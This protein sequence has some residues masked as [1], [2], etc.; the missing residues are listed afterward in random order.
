MR[1]AMLLAG[2]LATL[3]PGPPPAQADTDV[4]YQGLRIPAPAGWEVHHLGPRSTECLRFDRH[5]VY[6][7]SAGE[8]QDCPAHAVGRTTAIHVEPLAAQTN[9]LVTG[10]LARDGAGGG[11]RLPGLRV[12]DPAAHEILIAVPQA[13]A[14]ITGSYGSD[15]RDLERVLNRITLEEPTPDGAAERHTGAARPRRWV[16]GDGFDTCRAPS[17]DAMK[18]WRKDFVAANVY[19]GGVSRACPDGRLSH[20]WIA[21]V[22]GMGWR[23]IPTYVG[24]QAPCGPHRVNFTPDSAVDDARA[25]AEDAAERARLLGLRRLTPI[26]YDM[27]AY[28]RHDPE[29]REAVLDFLDAWTRKLRRLGYVPGVYSSVA[30]AIRDLA[31]AK[32][33]KKPSAV[34]FAHWDKKSDPW[35]DRYM[36]RDWWPGHRRIKQY[37]GDHRETHGGYTLNIDNDALDGYVR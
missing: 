31:A 14:F 11:G 28:S 3:I 26:Y 37:R 1:R 4:H 12:H 8:N 9:A 10:L 2:I 13:G 7:G 27:E 20:D 5:A 15:V 36:S 24:P 34:W 6:L 23:L 30:S 33:I 35:K 16:R 19:I 18:A 21:A 25:S 17:L 29:C 32:G 22:R